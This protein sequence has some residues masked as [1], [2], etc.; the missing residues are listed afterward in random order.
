MKQIVKTVLLIPTLLLCL[1][2]GA[3]NQSYD[4]FVPISKYIS[5]GNA[6]NLSAWFAD[7]LEITVL[8]RSSNASKNQAKQILKSFFVDHT[9]R[10]FEITHTAGKDNMKY[11]LGTL[12]AGGERFVITIFVNYDSDSYKI[13]QL[14]IDREI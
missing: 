7:N 14:K 8:S 10:S 9:P 6:E 3:Q 4:V 13:Q 12:I 5:Q 1:N 11:A 2:A